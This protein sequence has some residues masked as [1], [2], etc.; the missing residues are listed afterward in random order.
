M[1]AGGARIVR[2]WAAPRGRL[3]DRPHL[4]PHQIR[5]GDAV[6]TGAAVPDASSEMPKDSDLLK[7]S[8]LL[9]EQTD[10]R[11]V[12]LKPMLLRDVDT[13]RPRQPETHAGAVSALAFG[14][15]AS[16]LRTSRASGSGSPRHCRPL[17]D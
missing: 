8:E 11:W 2:G 10:R 16:E 13:G 1:P 17:A 7:H 4:Y 15:G 9:V 6:A 14:G 3:V 5:H 12:A